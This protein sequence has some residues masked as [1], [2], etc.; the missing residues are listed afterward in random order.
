[1]RRVLS[2]AEFLAW[3]SRC[4]PAVRSEELKP[5]PPA[6]LHNPYQV[7]LVGLMY[8][9]SGAMAGVAEKLPADDAR[10]AVLLDA[11]KDQIAAAGK[12]MFESDYGGTHWLATF[13]IYYYSGVGL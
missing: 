5:V 3:Y 12:L 6:D 13:A 4:L 9:K 1:M 2:R 7:H 11:V 8:E 10:R